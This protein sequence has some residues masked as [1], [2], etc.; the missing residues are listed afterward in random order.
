VAALT[1]HRFYQRRFFTILAAAFALRVAWALAVPIL[2]VSDSVVYD[3]LAWNIA[4]HGAYAW[5]N[6][7][8]TA[9][10]P[11][12]TA[13]IYSLVYRLFGHEV[14]PIAALNVILGTVSV[15]L[16]MVLARR[17]M[18]RATAL[19]AGAIYALWPSQIEFTSVLASELLF[20]FMLLLALW[21]TF[22][23]TV[24]SWALKGVLA[25]LF[26]AGAAYIRPTALPLVLLLAASLIWSRQAD[27]RA[28]VRFSFAALL[29]MSVC[30][31][32]WALRNLTQLGAPVIVSTNGPANLWMGNNPQS[33]GSYMPLPGDVSGMNEVD[34]SK[35][36]GA[37]AKSFIVEH[38]GRAAALFLRKLVITHDR[39]TIG[40]SWNESS[41]RPALG[42]RGLVIAKAASTAYWWLALALGLAGVFLVLA[43]QRWRG[44]LQP[45]LLAWGYFALVHAATVGA[46]RYHFASI[47]FIAML[48]GSAALRL[49]RVETVDK[50][51]ENP[52]TL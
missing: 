19:A 8:L 3:Q 44:L 41:L 18:S 30:L 48:A 42:D 37:R 47:P 50:P 24:R 16:V 26:L 14:A 17:W 10:W 34:R 51:T 25:G 4:A 27:W 11:V 7:E 31:A 29:A 12:G 52:K 1:A 46:D 21:S 39:E 9:Y 23:P 38:P 35:L 33:N 6:G 45:S 40:I 20:N 43:R 28:V 5:N 22:T 13:F 49:C 2:P 36:L 15:G 32:P